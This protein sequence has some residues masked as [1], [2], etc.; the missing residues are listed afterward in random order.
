[1]PTVG[2]S[3]SRVIQVEGHK[4][5]DGKVFTGMS[6]KSD[7]IRHQRKLDIAAALHTLKYD[8]TR[9]LCQPPQS[10]NKKRRFMRMI[11]KTFAKAV[12]KEP[13]DFIEALIQAYEF[14]PGGMRTVFAMIDDFFEEYI[15]E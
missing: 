10:N 14:N 6:G 12:Q 5:T 2:S 1:M 4:T 11:R 15:N 13:E 8:G 9:H 7:A 3:E